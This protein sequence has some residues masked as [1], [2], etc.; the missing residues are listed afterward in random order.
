M[1]LSFPPHVDCILYICK[2]L[3]HTD[4]PFIVY[5]HMLPSVGLDPLCYWHVIL[6]S[7]VTAIIIFYCTYFYL[8]FICQNNMVV[9]AQS[10][11]ICC[12][13]KTI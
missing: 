5:V 10:E 7:F 8:L 1:Q 4:S 9:K 6:C 12:L 2:C 11:I 13:K 3:C